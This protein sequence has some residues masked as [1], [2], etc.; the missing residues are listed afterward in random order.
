MNF[1]GYMRPPAVDVNGLSFHSDQL[2]FLGLTL[3]VAW[4]ELGNPGWNW[5][6]HFKYALR[7]E[8][9]KVST[10]LAVRRNLTFCLQIHTSV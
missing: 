10:P 8:R 9:C 4:E 2:R 7:A 3:P 5:E 6:N 1:M